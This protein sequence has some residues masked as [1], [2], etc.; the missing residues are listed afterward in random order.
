MNVAGQLV[1]GDAAL[2]DL[3]PAHARVEVLAITAGPIE[4]TAGRASFA[5]VICNRNRAGFAV[6]AVSNECIEHGSSLQRYA[7][8][9]RFGNNT[10]ALQLVHKIHKNTAGINGINQLGRFVVAV[11]AVAVAAAWK[12]RESFPKCG[13]DLFLISQD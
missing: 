10:F 3:I 1:D 4:C 9:Q 7:L 2:W 8:G 12:V 5:E 13:P 11:W 6:S